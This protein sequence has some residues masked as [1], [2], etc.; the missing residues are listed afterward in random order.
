LVR[1]DNM[2]YRQAII[3]I[4]KK[5]DLFLF[6][7]RPGLSEWNFPT[8]GQEQGETITDTFYRE[9]AEELGLKRDGVSSLRIS[10]VIHRYDW[11]E[12]HKVRTGHD[13]QEQHIVIAELIGNIDLSAQDELEEVKFVKGSELLRTIAHE[14]LRQTVRKMVAQGELE[15][16]E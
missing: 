14:D 1:V 6:A 7:R 10:C 13:G 16:V 9:I 15:G 8:G 2:T 11:E 3:I 12:K 4:L 5:G